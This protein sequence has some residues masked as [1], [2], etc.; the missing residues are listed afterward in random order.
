MKGGYYV[1]VLL[2]VASIIV[3]ARQI[4]LISVLIEDLY[5]TVLRCF[6]IL[7]VTN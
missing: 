4:D 2:L 3:I 5:F 7:P 6:S 1:L